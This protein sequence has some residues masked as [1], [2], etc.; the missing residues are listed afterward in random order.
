MRI[1]PCF[2]Q[3]VNRHNQSTLPAHFSRLLRIKNPAKTGHLS[4]LGEAV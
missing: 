2:E 4:H 3:G 1:A